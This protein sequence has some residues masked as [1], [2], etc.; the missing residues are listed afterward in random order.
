MALLVID[1]FFLI[2]EK[3]IEKKISTKRNITNALKT[4]TK[5]KKTVE[6]LVI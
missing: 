2:K 6:I 1:Y 3:H 4:T 5:Q